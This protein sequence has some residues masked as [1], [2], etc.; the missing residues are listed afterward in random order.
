VG[1]GGVPSFGRLLLLV[2]LAVLAVRCAVA[3]GGVARPAPASLR[4]SVRLLLVSTAG[5][6]RQLR[7]GAGRFAATDLD[8]GRLRGLRRRGLGLGRTVPTLESV[9]S[10]RLRR[11]C[12][13]VISRWVDT[14]AV[15]RSAK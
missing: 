12:R 7:S 4:V 11:G 1:L 6:R 2:M 3:A 15:A 14:C 10:C 13:A 5:V 8:G 9:A